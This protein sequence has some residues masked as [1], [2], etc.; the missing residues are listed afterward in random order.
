MQKEIGKR[1]SPYKG[2]LRFAKEKKSQLS[3]A[4]VL[5]V[6]SS[7]FGVV[8]Y[9]AVAV[10][11]Q[12][13]LENSLTTTW[14]I[15]LPVIALCGYLLKHTLYAKSTLCSHKVAYEIIKNIRTT[16][17]KKMSKV[18]MGTIQE[19][20][21]GEFKQLVIDDAE[22]LEG[23]LAHAIPEMTASILV[24]IFVILYLL[25]ID[26]RM[27]LAALVSAILG[28]LIYYG[29]MFGRGEVMKEYMMSNANMNATIVE[30]VNGMEVIKAFNQT[31]SSMGRFQSA[32]LKVRDITTKWYKHC[33]PFMSIS[34]AILPSSIAFVLPV[35]MALISGGAVS[36]AELIV[37][38]L[39]SMAIVGS[40]QNFTEFWES[41]A[42]ISEVQP[43]IQ[44][45]LDMEE[46][47]E[48][49]QPKHTD[50]ADMQMKDVH[51]GYGDSEIIHGISFTAKAGSVTAFV[52]PSGSG[53][54]TLAKLIARFWDVTGGSITLG[55][56]DIRKLPLKQLSQSISFV[57][58]DNF[59]FDCSLKENIR[60]GR[61]G[62]SDEEVLA[63]AKA[64]QCDA[65]VSKLPDGYHTL[66]GENGSRLSGGERQRISIARAIL[67]DA[68]VILLDEAT[69]SL[70]V[71]NETAVQAALSGLIKDKTVLIIA[72]RM[73]TVM[74]A[75]Q[76]VLL[77]GGRVVEMGSPA[78]LLKKNGLFRHM[79]QLQ[80]ESMEW[81]A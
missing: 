73:R 43:R 70:D 23:P 59:L 14:A 75:D 61:P 57:T 24:P 39:L 15:L 41:F 19:K 66:I 12:K 72:H 74:N 21:S 31:A 42:V 22:R 77:S 58:Q 27:A 71:E 69:A 30:Y 25:V 55:G 33:W 65:F 34:Q 53:K 29:M 47:T 48:P 20:S 40:L 8:P 35:G 4:V 64:A 1:E 10:L 67:K 60:L 7:A 46:L 49:A 9:I 28:N 38:I 80:S 56:Q 3:F 78:E 32:V 62:A 63:A 81:T 45:L 26:W 18:S 79:A 68:P 5:S 16:I 51:F 13:A 50:K 52:G 37:C 54:S 44:A 36:L 76:I 2:I 17:M 11:L 6:L